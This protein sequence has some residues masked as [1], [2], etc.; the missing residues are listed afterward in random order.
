MIMLIC[1]NEGG[2]AGKGYQVCNNEC[3]PNAMATKG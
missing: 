3:L 2:M 1:I